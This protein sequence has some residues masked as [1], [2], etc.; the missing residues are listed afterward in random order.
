M[1]EDKL[2]KL[3]QTEATEKID[4]SVLRKRVE[5]DIRKTKDHLRT[6]K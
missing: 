3:R 6:L 5:E 2:K 1:L 4:L